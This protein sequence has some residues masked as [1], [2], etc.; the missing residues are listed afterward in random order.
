MFAKK[1]GWA[2]KFFKNIKM[3]DLGNGRSEPNI[4]DVTREFN[5]GMWTIGY[6]GQSPERMKR[7]M[8]NQAHFDRTTLLA[9]GGPGK[10]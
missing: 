7:H 10:R 9:K 1:F 5:G 2:D 6:T 3:D 8:A 4:E